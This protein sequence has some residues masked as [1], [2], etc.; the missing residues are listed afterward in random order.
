RVGAQALRDDVTGASFRDICHLRADGTYAAKLDRA[1]LPQV[2]VGSN[3]SGAILTVEQ[4]RARRE[5]RI[6]RVEALGAHREPI[7]EALNAVLPDLQIPSLR[8]RAPD[9]ADTCKPSGSKVSLH[10]ELAQV[11]GRLVDLYNDQT[12]PAVTRGIG[13]LANRLAEDKEAQD[14]LAR[15]GAREGYRPMTMALGVLRPL[16]SYDRLPALANR[17]LR[18]LAS[19]THFANLARGRTDA[20][21][22]QPGNAHVAF[23]QLLSVVSAEMRSVE[24]RPTPEPL[25]VL[26][27]PRLDRAVLS[28]PRTSL[29][30]AKAL[31][32]D[33]NDSYR[34]G[35]S[36]FVAK[37]DLRGLVLVERV[38]GALPGLFL[39]DD[40]DGLAD[41]DTGGRF[42]TTDGALAPCPFPTLAAEQTPRDQL[43]RALREQGSDALLYQYVDTGSTLLS[44]L[45]RDLA[46]LLLTNVNDGRETIMD[47]LESLP[48]FLGPR[49]KVASSFRDYPPREPGGEPERITFRAF[50]G[51]E[52][53]ALD[54]VYGIG[55]LAGTNEL[56]TALGVL[57][58]LA[59][60]RPDA[61]ARTAGLLLDIKKTVDSHPEA[62]I[63]ESST[64]WDEALGWLVRVA[65][66]PGLLEDL[67][68]AFLDDRTVALDRVLSTWLTHRDVLT[69]QRDPNDK[70]N[71]DKLNGLPF[72]G[73]L[74]QV[75]SMGNPMG[76]PVDRSMPDTG[77][78]R[79]AAQ[80][81][82]Q[83]MHDSNGLSACTKEGAIAHL[84]INWPPSSSLAIPVDVDFPTSF[85]VSAICGFVGKKTPK[86][87][88]PPCGILRITNVAELLMD[89]TLGRA[90]L[91]IPDPCLQAVIKNK[92]LTAFVGGANY[93]LEEVSGIKGFSLDPTVEGVSRMTFFDT[94]YDAF[95]LSP[96]FAGD[97]YY[98]KTR[99]FLRDVMDP[100][101]SMVCDQAPYHYEENGQQKTIMLRKCDRYEDTLRGRDGDALVPLETMNFMELAK[102]IAAAFGDNHTPLLFS[103]ALGVLHRHWGTPAQS[104]QDCDPGLPDTHARWCSQAGAV[105]AEPMLADLLDNGFL[106]ELQSIFLSI[107][108]VRVQRCDA[109]DASGL[110]CLSAT[111]VD[112]I[113]AVAELVK[114]IVDPARWPN[115]TDR[116]GMTRAVWNDG[117]HHGPITPVTIMLDA[118]KGIDRAFAQD[119]SDHGRNASRHEAWLAA[120]SRLVDMLFAVQGKAA[121]TRFT[122]ASTVDALPNLVLILSQQIRANCRDANPNARCDWLSVDVVA[123]MQEAVSHPIL[124]AVLDALDQLRQDAEAREE[125]QRLVY[126]LLDPQAPNDAVSV[127]LAA[128]N[129]LVQVLSDDMN[130]APALRFGSE[131]AAPA[132]KG[133]FDRVIS[134]GLVDALV[135][136]LARVFAEAVDA[137]GVRNCAKEIDPNHAMKVVWERLVTPLQSGETPLEVFWRAAQ[138]VNRQNPAERTPLT[139]ADYASIARNVAD[140][141]LDQS[142]GLEQLYAVLRQASADNP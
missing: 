35:L 90:K 15:M 36:Q 97:D 81:I 76:A 60:Q 117:I 51:Q 42:L 103:D 118:L 61:L 134:S 106:R 55:L 4:M 1:R 11:L 126:Y 132:Q 49:D 79:S 18:N 94:P 21:D 30:L 3:T 72:N 80:R 62:Q 133:E 65:Q 27:D 8:L 50:H 135:E 92:Q 54:L 16:L 2:T 46:P 95:P 41:L 9:P 108:S 63:P 45:L 104:K 68:R 96:P 17:I 32:L 19:D 24:V 127:T 70:E 13:S 140:F 73:T 57:H 125:M 25:V 40:G 82:L 10:G 128:A 113:T 38:E 110:T 123:N 129:D 6:A 139:G 58:R 71:G 124:P 29:E 142:S 105:R 5:L 67:M 12:I 86:H 138:A 85:L 20:A 131:A 43:Q 47:L 141:C 107:A 116:H 23:Q 115:L 53:P 100:I 83:L 87:P 111:E 121:L 39:D 99:D 78:N 69:Y 64:F 66:V 33:V 91:D 77:E 112:G 34:R 7:V 114:L 120:R 136:L 48:V 14:A 84:K 28:R 119:A 74:G 130:L 44:A 89:V 37:R 59:V 75:V 22:A 56:D 52:S 31:L 93:F 122:N 137:S 102:P 88:L 101:P 109:Y 26:H 98:P